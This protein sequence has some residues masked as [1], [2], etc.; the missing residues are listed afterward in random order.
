MWRFC[1]ALTASLRPLFS[2][3][4]WADSRWDTLFSDPGR[5]SSCN[6][7]GSEVV[8]G[9]HALICFREG[10]WVLE[11]TGST[12]GTFLNEQRLTASQPVPLRSGSTVS[13]GAKGPRFKVEAVATAKLSATVVEGQPAVSPHDATVPMDAA[14]L[15]AKTAPMDVPPPREE[16]T[17]PNQ[18]LAAQADELSLDRPQGE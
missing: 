1:W 14:D 4:S 13:F 10:A 6:G 12:N 9:N 3:S 18:G 2:A 5:V 16:S 15:A 17:P 7:E 11:D 8:S